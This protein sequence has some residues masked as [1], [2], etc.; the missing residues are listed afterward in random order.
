[1]GMKGSARSRVIALRCCALIGGLYGHPCVAQ[2]I[3]MVPLAEARLREEYVEQGGLAESSDAVTLR[4]RTGVQVK[5]EGWSALVEAQGTLAIVDRYFDGLHGSA[6]RPVIADPQNIALYRAQLQ[7]RGKAVALTLGRQ[8]I[9]LDD[10]RFVDA[11]LFRQNAQTY[12]AVRLEWT[13]VPHLRVDATYAWQVRTI[14]GIDGFGV[15]PSSI[16]G[17]NVFVEV[18]HDSPVGRITGFGYL[19]SQNDPAYQGFRLSSQT[20]GARFAGNRPLTAH[21][22]INYKL[23]Y[24]YQSDWQRNP[25][26]YSARFY[27]FDLSLDI[28]RFRL[29]AAYEVTGASNGTAFT[30]FQFPV[31]AGIRYRGFTNKFTPTPPDGLRDLYGS[32]ALTVPTAGRFRSVTAQAVFH[33]FE[34]DRLVRHYGN[35]IDLQLSGKIGRYTL[36]A[37]YGEYDPDLF[38]TRTRKFWLQLDWAL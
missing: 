38:A 35:E 12:D 4:L 2:T 11:A 34:S 6:T 14:W 3:A 28:A 26:R 25:N 10:D 16:G 13:G 9:S 5:A 21:A 24:A 20:F 32:V 15:R 17:D 33:R 29:G 37:R 31:G 27:L 19:A 23:T 36:M 1:M 7:Y 8:R 18:S 22:K 30:S